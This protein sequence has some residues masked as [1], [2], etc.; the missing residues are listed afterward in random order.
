MS[1]YTS[2]SNND[3]EAFLAGYLIGKLRSFHG[4]KN[5]ITN[6]NYWL[7]TEDGDYVLTL[8]EQ[9]Q[10]ETLDYIL[11]LQLHLSGQG[12]ACSRPVL[13]DR[14]RLFSMLKKKPAAIIHRLPGEAATVFSRH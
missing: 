11:G 3:I 12:V 13:D 1:V 7:S 6:T 8:Y 5:G 10:P 2:V 4:I 14:Q 9:H